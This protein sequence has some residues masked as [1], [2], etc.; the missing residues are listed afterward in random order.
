ML[1]VGRKIMAEDSDMM[2][3]FIAARKHLVKYRG[4]IVMKL[5]QL[6]HDGAAIAESVAQV[7]FFRTAAISIIAFRLV[8]PCGEERP[9]AKG[10]GP[11]VTCGVEIVHD[12]GI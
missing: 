8:M 9:R 1:P 6:D 12:P 3:A 7:A 10:F 11:A 5:D 2:E 4:R